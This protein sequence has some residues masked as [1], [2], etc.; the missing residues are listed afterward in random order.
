MSGQLH[1]GRPLAVPADGDRVGR[2]PWARLFASSVVRD[3][4][5]ATAER[6]RALA[7]AGAVHAVSVTP[8]EVAGR[9]EDGERVESA[10]IATDPVPPRVWH[11]IAR[12]ARGNARLEEAV[13]GRAQSVHLEHVMTLDWEEP[14]V[15]RAGGLLRSCTCRIS[16]CEHVAALAFALAAEIDREPAVLLRWRGCVEEG[17]PVAPAA[18]PVPQQGD[19]W[20]GGRLPELG[21]PRPLPVA[22]V[23]KRLGPSGVRVVGDPL[24]AVL[25][26]AYA[27]FSR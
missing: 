1:E 26:R 19:P 11:A 27:A 16:G 22:A 21:P 15:P 4:G 18:P 8:G 24:E 13:A 9:V 12:S 7:R 14:L 3:E 25:E 6:G 23:L 5:A 2:G 10:R 17:E 20:Q